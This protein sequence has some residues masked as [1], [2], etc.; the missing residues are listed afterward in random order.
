MRQPTIC[1]LR[2]GSEGGSWIGTGVGSVGGVGGGISSS[3]SGGPGGGGS[4]G[5]GG[6][7][8]I[9]VVARSPPVRTLSSSF[10]ATLQAHADMRQAHSRRVPDGKAVMPNAE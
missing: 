6:S 5:V 4:R 7:S 2:P 10:M 1:G 8:G 3:S 9:P